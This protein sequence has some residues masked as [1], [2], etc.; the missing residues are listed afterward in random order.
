MSAY[1]NIKTDGGRLWLW[2]LLLRIL[3]VKTQ[4]EKRR[5]RTF[6]CPRS[7]ELTKK[8]RRKKKFPLEKGEGVCWL[9]RF[10]SQW[11]Q[12][13]L[14][15]FILYDPKARGGWRRKFWPNFSSFTEQQKVKRKR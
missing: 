12:K 1:T 15:F 5:M 11:K 14:I 7:K 3:V 4:E 10:V 9:F 6:N 8:K 2:L 13:Q